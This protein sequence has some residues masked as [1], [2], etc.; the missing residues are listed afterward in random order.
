MTSITDAEAPTLDERAEARR[1]AVAALVDDDAALA[2]RVAAAPSSYVL[3]HQATDIARQCRLLTPLPARGAVRAVLTPGR[4]GFE[5]RLDVASRDRPGLLAACT[6][7]VARLGID[8]VQAV[9]ATWD[10][11]AALEAFVV[12]TPS[13]PPQST[14]QSHLQA[15]LTMRFGPVPI[16]DATLTFDDAASSVYT[17]CTITSRDRPGL[18]HDIAGG[19]AIAGI[20]IHAARVTTA[21]GVATDHFDLTDDRARKLDDAAKRRVLLTLTTDLSG[22]RY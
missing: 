3:V 16:E 1:R 14:L 5:W 10:D 9:V 2:G 8:V 11:G 15:A 7:A 13:P 22:A 19:F 6:G 18:L 20:D 12:R 4:A 21:D 17:A